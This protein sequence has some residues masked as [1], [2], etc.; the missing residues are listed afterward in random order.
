M[1]RKNDS[2]KESFDYSI[3]DMISYLFELGIS[4]KV[5]YKYYQQ[6]KKGIKNA[7]KK[8]K[9]SYV[10]LFLNSYNRV[11]VSILRD[12]LGSLNDEQLFQIIEQSKSEKLVE[13]LIFLIR[14]LLFGR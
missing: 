14:K 3:K 5:K 2:K 12:L 6:N 4:E 1:D 8:E 9:Y 7:L 10:S 11:P 13:K